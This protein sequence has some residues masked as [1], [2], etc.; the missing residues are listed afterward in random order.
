MVVDDRTRK[1]IEELLGG[2]QVDLEKRLKDINTRLSEVE[3][4]LQRIE[5]RIKELNN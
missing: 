3:K 2:L 5:K 4:A 1:Y